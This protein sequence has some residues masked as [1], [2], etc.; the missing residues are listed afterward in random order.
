MSE[1]KEIVG[2]KT[3]T[4]DGIASFHRAHQIHALNFIGSHTLLHDHG[5]TTIHFMLSQQGIF[6]HLRAGRAMRRSDERKKE[7]SAYR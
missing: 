5:K 4:D 3:R 1:S 6:E 2:D 7:R